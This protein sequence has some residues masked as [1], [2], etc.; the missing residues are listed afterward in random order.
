MLDP[1]NTSNSFKMGS[2]K[3]IDRAE[4]LANCYLNHSISLMLGNIEGKFNK[5]DHIMNSLR[6]GQKLSKEILKSEQWAARFTKY[7][8]DY[9][10]MLISNMPTDREDSDQY[11]ISVNVQN[12]QLKKKLS[13]QSPQLQLKR[14]EQSRPKETSARNESNFSRIRV[15]QD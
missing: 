13:L 3:F 15:M 11:T 4:I 5:K 14:T 9:V 10:T 1:F 2:N 6:K 12:K 8:N 7:M